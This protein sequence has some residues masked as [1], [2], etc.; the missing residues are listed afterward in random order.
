M[1][2]IAGSF[3]VVIRQ[4]GHSIR[5]VKTTFRSPDLYPGEVAIRL[6]VRIPEAAFRPVSP[7]VTVTVPEELVSQPPLVEVEVTDANEE[8]A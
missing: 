1:S 2:A 4:H 5:P 8:E 3:Y 7:E 6:T